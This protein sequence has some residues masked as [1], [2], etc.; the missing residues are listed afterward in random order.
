MFTM[1]RQNRSSVATFLIFCGLGLLA[2]WAIGRVYYS[3]EAIQ[4]MESLTSSGLYL[5][6]ASATASATIIALMLTLTGMIRRVDADFDQNVWVSVDK[7]SQLAIVA[8]LASLT[9]LLVLVFPIGEFEKL[10]AGWFMILY[11][12]LFGLTVLV[13][14]L[15]SATAVMLYST[16]R[17][18]IRAITPTD[19][20]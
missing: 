10:P 16:L 11:D 14:A 4:L 12:I 17:C 19:E 6:S 5:G 18:V 3:G 2:R 9:L 13:I 7:V 15:L 8:L 20:V 1:L